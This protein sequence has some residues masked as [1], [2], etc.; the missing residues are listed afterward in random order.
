[1][2]VNEWPRIWRG[3]RVERGAGCALGHLLRADG[4]HG[5]GGIAPG[6][7]RGF[8]EKLGVR[9]GLGR[10]GSL[11]DVG[12]GS[13]ALLYPF[14]GDGVRVGGIDYAERQ[15]RRARRFMPAGEFAVGDAAEMPVEPR[16]DAVV[17][18]SVFQYFPSEEHAAEVL[19][20]M[21]AKATRTVAVLDVP[22]LTRR[23]EDE[24]RR[25]AALGAEEYARR[26]A[27]LPLRYY[28]RAWFAATLAKF[29]LGCSFAEQDMPGYAHAGFR[30]HVFVAK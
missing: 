14:Y 10:G 28:D 7:W 1:M 8:T 6:V 23:E 11:Y 25:R 15:A 16:W 26:Y 5:L 3:R 9:I 27:G 22:D 2:N 18:H 4:F 24:A 30:Y 21:V 20:R 19:R 13:G 29:G 12:C 17:A